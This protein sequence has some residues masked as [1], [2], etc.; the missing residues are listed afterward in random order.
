MDPQSGFKCTHNFGKMIGIMKHRPNDNI[1]VTNL[2]FFNDKSFSD[3][4][5]L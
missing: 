3:C 1:A 2:V 5:I 4:K